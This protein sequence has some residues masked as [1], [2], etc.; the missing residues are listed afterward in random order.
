MLSA[1][2]Q[3]NEEVSL[4][5]ILSFLTTVLMR[6]SHRSSYSSFSFHH[7]ISFSSWSKDFTLWRSRDCE[8]AI[9]ATIECTYQRKVLESDSTLGELFLVG[10]VLEG[11]T[12]VRLVQVL[13]SS[14][15]RKQSYVI[16][17][18]QPVIAKHHFEQFEPFGALLPNNWLTKISFYKLLL[19]FYNKTDSIVRN[20]S[21][22][23]SF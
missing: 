3:L 14:V 23:H 12:A 1:R 21:N 15:S 11:T 13:L 19:S 9:W 18:V 4:S 2:Q 5:M 7:G 20:S 17:S 22:H 16:A 6:Y 8:Y 10:V